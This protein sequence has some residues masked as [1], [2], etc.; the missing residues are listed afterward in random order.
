[1][2]ISQVSTWTCTI[3]NWCSPPWWCVQWSHTKPIVPLIW[4]LP[5]W[6]EFNA[7]RLW[8]DVVV[9]LTTFFVVCSVYDDENVDVIEPFLK[10][11][12]QLNYNTVHDAYIES[13]NITR[14]PRLQNNVNRKPLR[15]MTFQVN[16]KII[17]KICAVS[18]S[19]WVRLL[20]AMESLVFALQTIHFALCSVC[21]F[22]NSLWLLAIRRDNANKYGCVALRTCHFSAYRIYW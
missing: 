3:N 22:M 17:R 2:F 21:L 16:N 14:D 7:G 1:M 5:I 15:S 12:P 11:L 10:Y 4:H 18:P 13:M 6:G 9:F 19:Y 20:T 8:A